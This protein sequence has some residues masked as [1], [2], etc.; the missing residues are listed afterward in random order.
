LLAQHLGAQADLA[1]LGEFDGVGQEV[2]Q[3]LLDA[4]RIA[5]HRFRHGR[6]EFAADGQLLGLGALG[7]L[8][9]GIEAELVQRKVGVLE[10]QLVGLDL[11][12]VE[13]VVDDGQQVMGRIGHLAQAL[14]LLGVAGVALG[15]V[16]EA[17]DGIHRRADFMAHVGQEG[18]L[19]AV[20]RFGLILGAAQFPR[21]FID[22][23]FEVLAVAF[24]FRLDPFFSVM[25]SLM[26][27]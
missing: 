12:D 3:D 14:V 2:E 27:R 11:G 7:D 22:Q 13:N 17:D 20:G 5:A 8:L 24:Q 10:Q 19:G 9:A 1:A 18:A 25:S 26:P 16:G 23:L 6:V 15:E 21:A 4:H